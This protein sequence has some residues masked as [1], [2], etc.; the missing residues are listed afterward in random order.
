MSTCNISDQKR[1]LISSVYKASDRRK[2]PTKALH[3]LG[4]KPP[5]LLV[6]PGS[7]LCSGLDH[8]LS[9]RSTGSPGQTVKR[10]PCQCLLA[11]W[12]CRCPGPP[13]GA[14]GWRTGAQGALWDLS[15]CAW[16]PMAQV[17]EPFL[18]PPISL[19]LS[20]SPP[21]QGL[22]WGLPFP[23]ATGWRGHLSLVVASLPYSLV[24]GPLNADAEAGFLRV[25]AAPAMHTG[26][27]RLSAILS[28]PQLQS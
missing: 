3:Q 14:P 25:A 17:S 21:P 1:G 23:F 18:P 9:I 7:S 24:R 10:S 28:W 12:G 5:A 8:G 22:L 27:P 15:V 19:S 11:S 2:C 26:P 6:T 20:C 4:L 13:C 16:L